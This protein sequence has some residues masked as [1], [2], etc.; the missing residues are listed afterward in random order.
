MQPLVVTKTN[1]RIAAATPPPRLW[2]QFMRGSSSSPPHA[3]KRPFAAPSGQHRCRPR[4][5]LN[6]EPSGRHGPEAYRSYGASHHISAPCYRDDAP[7]ALGLVHAREFIISAARAQGRW[8]E[9]ATR[10]FRSATRR[11]EWERAMKLNRT[12]NRTSSPLRWAGRPTPQASGLPGWG[13]FRRGGVHHFRHARARPP[14]EV[15]RS[16]RRERRRRRIYEVVA[17]LRFV[18][19]IPGPVLYFLTTDERGW[20]Q[21]RKLSNSIDV[22]RR[23]SVVEFSSLFFSL[24]PGE[25]LR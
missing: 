25:L 21:I 9:Q 23:S 16:G 18:R 12:E 15:S 1:R 19:A 8:V 2:G 7:T 17:C 6:S 5:V 14:P 11:T 20:M 24:S 4:A 10:L 13:R 3:R 22:H